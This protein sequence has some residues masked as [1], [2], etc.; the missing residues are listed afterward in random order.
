[1]RGR[2]V[3]LVHVLVRHVEEQRLRRVVRA[4]DVVRHVVEQVGG[5]DPVDVVHDGKVEREALHA[6][7]LPHH[8]VVALALESIRVRVREVLDSVGEVAVERV[9]STSARHV[10]HREM[11]QMPLPNHVRL[12]SVLLE[13]LRQGLLLQRQAPRRIG[14][15]HVVV[16]P[17]P[18]RVFARH[19]STAGRGAQLLPIVL[20]QLNTS[21]RHRIKGRSHPRK[22]V[23]AVA[24]VVEALVVRKNEEHVHGLAR[25][26]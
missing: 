21:V 26:V 23:R 8:V 17:D 10:L 15:D 24:N 22:V 1:M 20:S 7:V 12:V 9:E 4:Q 18:N 3:R 5:V 2:G 16:Q 6:A 11:A 14:V 19:E 13:I 25:V